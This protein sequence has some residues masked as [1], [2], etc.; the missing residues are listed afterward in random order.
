MKLLLL[1]L[2][3]PVAAFAGEVTGTLDANESACTVELVDGKGLINLVGTWD[4]ATVKIDVRQT[5]P[6]GTTAW[7]EDTSWAGA[8]DDEIG[9]TVNYQRN[10]WIRLTMSGAGTEDVDCHVIHN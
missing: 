7:N 10:T 6:D 2:L 4:T 8:T 5:L 1:L 3:M 9:K